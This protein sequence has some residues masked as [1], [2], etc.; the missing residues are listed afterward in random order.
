MCTGRLVLL[1]GPMR[2]TNVSRVSDTVSRPDQSAPQ[3]GKYNGQRLLGLP[4]HPKWSR[5]PLAIDCVRWAQ[6][7]VDSTD[8]F[9]RRGIRRSQEIVSIIVSLEDLYGRSGP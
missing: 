3:L 8:L 4:Y 5:A 9:N 2:Q 6:Y 1:L 7:N